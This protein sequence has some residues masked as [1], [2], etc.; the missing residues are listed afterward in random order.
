LPWDILSWVKLER[1]LCAVD[2]MLLFC[3]TVIGLGQVG[4][5]R[6]G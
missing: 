1:S 2:A 4:E 3:W 6:I 5:V